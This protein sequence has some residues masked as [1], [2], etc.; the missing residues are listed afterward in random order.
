MNQQIT[1]TILMIRPATFRMN[2]ETAINN[3]FQKEQ[4]SIS[5]LYGIVGLFLIYAI[6]ASL[7]NSAT[8][9]IER[10]KIKSVKFKKAAF[11]ITRSRFEILFEENNGKIKKRL[12]ML[13]GSMSNGQKETEKARK[14]MKEEKLFN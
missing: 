3:Y 8:P 2:E 14:I 1:N 12:I 4:I 5:V 13:P 9:I 11:G 10:S 7:N 6:F